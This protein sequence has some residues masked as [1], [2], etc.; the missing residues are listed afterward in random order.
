MPKQYKVTN[1]S[2]E[3]LLEPRNNVRIKAG[4][5]VIVEQMVAETIR[6]V[7][8]YRTKLSDVN[9]VPTQ[10][11]EP[12]IEPK[13]PV[14]IKPEEVKVDEGDQTSEELKATEDKPTKKK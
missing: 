6:A 3:E 9:M 5:S 12:K 2:S 11:V 14:E 10:K 8:P 13:A 4:E 1:T 7:F